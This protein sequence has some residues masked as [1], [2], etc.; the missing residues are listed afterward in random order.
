MPRVT[1]ILVGKPGPVLTISADASVYDAIERMVE[2]NVGSL[3]VLDGETVAGIFTERDHLR[4]VTLPERSPRLTPIREV[5]TERIL[6]VDCE[7]SI[8]DCMG[9]MTQQRIRHLPVMRGDQLAG[10]ISIG[11]LVKF[12]ADS[13]EVEVRHL[14]EY[15]MGERV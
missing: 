14:T 2:H 9:I 6:C 5:M 3:V 7:T 4:R 8:A 1:E 10:V 12:V 13:R 11:D 15:I